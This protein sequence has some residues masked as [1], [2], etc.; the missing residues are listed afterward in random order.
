VKKDERD[1]IRAILWPK[2]KQGR[3]SFAYLEFIQPTGLFDN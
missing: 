1:G 2:A 3:S